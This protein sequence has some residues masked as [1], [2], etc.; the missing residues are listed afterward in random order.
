MIPIKKPN[1]VFQTY[2]YW[3]RFLIVYIAGYNSGELGGFIKLLC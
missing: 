2:K 3:N 1:K